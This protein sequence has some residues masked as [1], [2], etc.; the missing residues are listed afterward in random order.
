MFCYFPYF[1]LQHLREKKQPLAHHGS[2]PNIN[3]GILGT[4]SP[5]LWTCLEEPPS[6]PPQSSVWRR[7]APSSS[8]SVG[9]WWRRFR[10]LHRE[11]SRRQEIGKTAGLSLCC[12]SFNLSDKLLE[13]LG[14]CTIELISRLFYYSFSHSSFMMCNRVFFAAVSATAL[15]LICCIQDIFVFLFYT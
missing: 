6:A 9:S 4:A 8:C 5:P 14:S 7:W 13:W 3:D 1:R 15:L 11:K 10:A 12:S 2:V